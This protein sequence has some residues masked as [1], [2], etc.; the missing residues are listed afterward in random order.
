MQG[1]AAFLFPRGT[2]R[3]VT[4]SSRWEHVEVLTWAVKKETKQEAPRLLPLRE[5]SWIFSS[6]LVTGFP[7]FVCL[8]VAVAGAV[9][10]G[11]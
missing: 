5:V 10:I 4:G 1:L 11:E 8:F 9:G 2:A 3:G 6:L 7:L